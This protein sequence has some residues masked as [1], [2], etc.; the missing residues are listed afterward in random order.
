MR[1]QKAFKIPKLNNSRTNAVVAELGRESLAVVEVANRSNGI[2]LVRFTVR[3]LPPEGMNPAWLRAIWRQEHF[4]QQRA[5]FCLPAALVKYKS[6][7]MPFLPPAQLEAA[8]KLEL[9]SGNGSHQPGQG[10]AWIIKLIDW[11]KQDRMLLANA[12]LIEKE[13]L[14][15]ALQVFQEAGIAVEWSGLRYQGLRNFINF[16]GGFWDDSSEGAIYL[17]FGAERTELGIIRNEALVYRRELACGCSDLLNE[18]EPDAVADFIEELRLSLAAYQAD[19]K[20]KLPSKLGVF[21]RTEAGASVS[22]QLDEELGLHC[23]TPEKTKLTG[24][25]THRHTPRLA[26]LIGLA[27]DKTAVSRPGAVHI[28]TPEQETARGNREKLVMATGVAMVIMLLLSGI[29]L[30]L[31]ASTVKNTQTGVWLEHHAALLAKLRRME[32]Q[33]S[34]NANKIKQINDW[35]AGQNREL[36]FLLLLKNNLPDGAQITD[37][38]I[39]NGI[40]KD[41]SGVAPSASF[42]LNKFETV[43]G[44]QDL[45][46]KGT[47]TAS[48]EG[49]IFQLEGEIG[50]KGPTK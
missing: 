48:L 34:G 28:H 9:E 35:L 38:T 12:A 36:E 23:Y 49:E 22:R 5:V 10:A 1:A 40:I 20:K 50:G 37:L 6:L 31:Q 47:I 24:V 33:T 3:P 32:R 25:I 39:E 45:K 11:Q 42:L 13:P 41:L 14:T 21:G 18:Q 43:P 15:K 44:L 7:L 46:L 30:G 19:S 8:V 27:L 16:N 26:P 4:S 2:E 17:D 29:L